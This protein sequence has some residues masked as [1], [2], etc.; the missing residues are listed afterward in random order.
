VA[1][2]NPQFTKFR[3][4]D[5]W[6]KSSTR[7]P[8]PH[9]SKAKPEAFSQ[10]GRRQRNIFVDDE[11]I[12]LSTT[13]NSL[14]LDVD[15]F[16]SNLG[17]ALTKGVGQKS[18]SSQGYAGES[19]KRKLNCVFSFSWMLKPFDERKMNFERKKLVDF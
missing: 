18:T 7:R 11:E 10:L 19:Q 16:G 3:A 2:A 13:S 8:W 14:L 5:L 6:P 9:A 15:R 4:F 17:L 1:G 12:Y